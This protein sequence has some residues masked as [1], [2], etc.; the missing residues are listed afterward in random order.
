MPRQR[1]IR[2]SV[3]P[4]T[5]TDR[6]LTPRTDRRQQRQLDEIDRHNQLLLRESPFVRKQFMSNLDTS[7]VEKYK[8]SV[9][10]YRRIFAEDVIGKFDDKLL[11]FNP[12]TR[13]A[14]DEQTWTGYEVVLDVYFYCPNSSF[15]S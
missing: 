2:R 9:E 3:R 10:Q 1:Q 11:P 8:Q 12:R 13:K 4:A 14:Y 7:S 6:I 5:K 15:P